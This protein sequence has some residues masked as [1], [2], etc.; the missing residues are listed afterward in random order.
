MPQECRS[1]LQKAENE[2][3]NTMN[4]GKSKCQEALSN[5]KPS[6]IRKRFEKACDAFKIGSACNLGSAKKKACNPYP[7]MERKLQK[8]SKEMKKQLSK[9]QTFFEFELSSDFRIG[10]DLTISKNSST[11][12][13]EVK[14]DILLRVQWFLNFITSVNNILIFTILLLFISSLIYIKNFR[15]KDHYDN[16]YITEAFKKMDEACQKK[17]QEFVLPLTTNEAIWHVDVTSRKPSVLEMS[18][19]TRELRSIVYHLVIVALVIGFDYLLHYSLVLVE[20]YGDVAL[21]IDGIS[22]VDVNLQGNGIFTKLLRMTID[23]LTV[24][25]TFSVNINFTLCLPNPSKPKTDYLPPIGILY[26]VAV[27]LAISNAYAMRLRRAIAASFYPEQ[28]DVRI[29]YLH[30]KL[31]Y[32]RMTF[33]NWLRDL[34]LMNFKKGQVRERMSFRAYLG[35]KYPKLVKYFDGCIPAQNTCLSCDRS[36][37]RGMVFMKCTT[38]TCKAIYCENCFKA[39]KKYCLVCETR[40]EMNSS[41]I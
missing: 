11:V 3:K 34:V 24:N 30:E 7:F 4:K 29:H 9:V 41:G 36:G 2:C 22:T 31:I 12:V 23:T 35:Y 26:A 27:V 14:A 13:A 15:S 38:E 19:V 6:F 16:I 21:T 8:A 32:G 33:A 28:E 1:K 25:E 40:N 10:G 37:R 18:A 20:K 39:M 17:Q 5:I